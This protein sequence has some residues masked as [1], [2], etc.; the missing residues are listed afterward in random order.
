MGRILLACAS[1]E[2]CRPLLPQGLMPER[3]GGRPAYGL[4]E[5][6]TVVVCGV[7]KTNT[8]QAV[9]AVIEHAG[10]A[11]RGG[12]AAVVSFGSAGAFL[13]SGL[14]PGDVAVAS[15]EVTDELVV[16]PGR[17]ATLAEIGLPLLALDP[18]LHNRFPVSDALTRRLLAACRQSALPGQQTLS[19]AFLTVSRITCCR[20]EADRLEELLGPLLCENMEGAAAAQVA[21][22]YG[23]AFA[24]VRSVSNLVDDRERQSWDFELAARNCC[25]VVR[26]FLEELRL[27]PL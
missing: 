3:I 26:F 23:L 21:H 15:E 5:G 2:E 11:E 22:H 13:S 10:F 16:L 6:A 7:G 24:E 4:A 18:P 12:F 1:L 14:S 20:E 9:T 25:R 19:G 8:A 27:H 17:L